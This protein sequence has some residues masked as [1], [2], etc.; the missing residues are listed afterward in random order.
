MNKLII[1]VLAVAVIVVVQTAIAIRTYRRITRLRW[2]LPGTDLLK[3]KEIIVPVDHLRELDPATI[4]E[5]VQRY[6]EED[7]DDLIRQRVVFI[8]PNE[9]FAPGFKDIIS[10]INIDL[11]KNKGLLTDPQL[12]KDT[13]DRQ[14]EI[15]EDPVIHCLPVPLYMGMAGT[16]IGIGFGLYNFYSRGDSQVTFDISPLLGGVSVAM[17]SSLWGLLCT[18]MNGN[19]A[20]N[21]AKVLLEKGKTRFYDF[22]HEKLFPVLHQ[23]TQPG[24]TGMPQSLSRFNEDFSKNLQVL[25]KILSKKY[26][27][28]QTL[29]NIE[30]E[31]FADANARIL[32]DLHVTTSHLQ[33]FNQNLDTMNSLSNGLSQLAGSFGDILSRTN[34]FKDLAEKLNSR[35]EES[36][37]LLRF[38]HDHFHQLESRGEIIN[39][40]VVKVEDMVIKS[41]EKFDEQLNDR[42]AIVSRSVLEMEDIMLKS[43]RQLEEH[44]QT[45]IEAIRQLTS[46]EG[47]HLA[48]TFRENGTQISKLSLLEDL[49][50]SVGVIRRS[51]GGRIDKLDA[52]LQLLRQNLEASIVILQEINRKT[53]HRKSLTQQVS[54]WFQ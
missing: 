52:E 1:E 24:I 27:A 5:N 41:L 7:R 12:V 22:T 30:L 4:L 29:D 3:I 51:T 25:S 34:H 50:T 10:S 43:L 49:N 8:E 2:L 40:A 32:K 53:H 54:S 33:H 44:T 15:Q 28:L 23:S 35:V 17:F 31:K 46:E 37:Q 16:I 11:I 14:L 36:N 39:K 9:T 19:F 18:V 13:V 48:R 45:K 26:E 21:S 42:L 6:E 38:L 20:F 47:D